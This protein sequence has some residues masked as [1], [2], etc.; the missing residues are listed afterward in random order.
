MDFDYTDEQK[1]FAES[2][3]RFAQDRLNQETPLPVHFD[4]LAVVVHARE[5]FLPRL[6]VRRELGQFLLDPAPIPHRV[7][8]YE[9]AVLTGHKK[10]VALL[11]QLFQKGRRY[12]QPALLVDPRLIVAKHLENRHE[13]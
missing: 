1:Q 4:D 5:K 12:F 7:D 2:V 8:A 13:R 3:R 11:A 6:I 9:V 10:L